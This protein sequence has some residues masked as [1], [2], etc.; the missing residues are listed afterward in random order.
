MLQSKEIQ[1]MNEKTR[2]IY[3]MLTRDSHQFYRN[4]LKVGGWTK[5]SSVQFRHS[6][7]ANSLWP[8]RLQHTRLYITC[9]SPC[10]SPTPGG[11]WN[12]CPLIQWCHPTISSS[13]VH[14]CWLQL[15]LASRSFPWVSYLINRWPKHCS[16]SF[17]I[18]PST[19]YSRLISFR[20]DF[21][22]LSKGLSRVFSSITIQK[23]QFFGSQPSLW[24]TSHAHTW[25]LEK[26]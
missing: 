10:T 3:M 18:S 1:W 20:I 22:L 2:T 19:E 17:S 6:V 5:V 26:P 16:F 7:I 13:V 4:K 8:H 21:S 11:W 23:H 25:L 24:S 9:T 15:F 12:S 14:F